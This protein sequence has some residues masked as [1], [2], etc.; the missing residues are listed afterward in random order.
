[1]LRGE[2]PV[3]VPRLDGDGMVA[4]GVR[5]PVVAAA[6]ATYTGWNPRADGYGSSALCPLAGGVVPLARTRG[7]RAADDPRPSVE[8]RFPNAAAYVAAVR[9]AA[10]ALVHDRLLLPED[11]AAQIQ[12]ARADRLAK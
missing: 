7:E 8:E 3:Y 2:Y 1:M 6:K 10:E 5:L 12:A 11:A 9:T 4:R